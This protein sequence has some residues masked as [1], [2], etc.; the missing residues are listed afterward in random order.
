MTR[1]ER[2]LV[3]EDIVSEIRQGYYTNREGEDIDISE[4]LEY[5]RSYSGLYPDLLPPIRSG[6]VRVVRVARNPGMK[7]FTENIDTFSKARQYG[8]SGVC[9]NMASFS[10]PGGGFLSGASAQEES[11]CRRSSLIASIS[12]FSALGDKLF[13]CSREKKGYPLGMYGAIYSPKIA[14]WKDSLGNNFPEPFL[15]NVISLPAIKNPALD[16]SGKLKSEV[17]NQEKQKIRQILRVAFYSRGYRFLVL[18]ALGCGAYHTPPEEMAL[19]FKE[20][21]GEEEF[22]VFDE[23]CFAVLD[24]KNSG[25]GG[26]YSVFK[27]ILG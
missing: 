19:C 7:V 18:G 24:D 27:K 12:M 9:L 13:D 23:V 17:R 21:L 10:F 22:R 25:P 15:T 26:N 16:S 8:D 3:A 11:L 5:T 14:V 4:Y 2:A 6:V 1:E 20:V